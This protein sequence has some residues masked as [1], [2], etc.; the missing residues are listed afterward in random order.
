MKTV[1]TI[2]ACLLALAAL[3]LLSMGEYAAAAVN[4]TVALITWSS[5]K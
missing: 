3:L 5:R 4:A 2:E 1:P